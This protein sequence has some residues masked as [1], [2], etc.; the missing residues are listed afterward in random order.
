MLLL[1]VTNSWYNDKQ[2]EIKILMSDDSNLEAVTESSTWALECQLSC[3]A[4]PAA[5]R[6]IPRTNQRICDHQRDV[7]RVWPTCSFNGQRNVR[8][9]HLV[10]SYPHLTT[11][12]STVYIQYDLNTL[13]SIPRSQI[14]CKHHV[15]N[16]NVHCPSAMTLFI[17]VRLTYM[18]K[19]DF[20]WRTLFQIV[21]MNPI[22]WT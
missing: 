18:R 6:A 22:N 10:I 1:W 20:Q 4:T 13:F 5:D 17:W 16:Y 8:M 21:V 14:K 19:R 12:K 7:V 15:Y 11:S 3:H 2:P 9:R